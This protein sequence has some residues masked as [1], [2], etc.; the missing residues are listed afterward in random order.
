MAEQSTKKLVEIADIKENIVLLKNGSLRAILEVSAINFELRSA[1]EQIAILQNFQRFLNSI[2]FPIQIVVNSRQLDMT[3]YLKL[4]ES[5]IESLQ[6][7]L[8]RIQA[9]EYSK[10]IKELLDLSNIMAKRFYIVIPFYVLERPS[11]ENLM[12]G[13]KGIFKPSS[14]TVKIKP[15]QIESYRTQ[16]MQRVEL[17]FDGLVGMSLKAKLLGQEGLTKLFYGL[18]NPEKYDSSPTN[19]QNY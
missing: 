3:N 5:V 1:D 14:E 8:L 6:N 18:Y 16:L 7:E 11:K 19:G 2:D 4:L 12:E 17:V 13:V 9:I 10:F 15:E